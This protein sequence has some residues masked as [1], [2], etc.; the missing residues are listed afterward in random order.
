MVLVHGISGSE[1]SCYMTVAASYLP[2]ARLSGAAASIC[3]A[4]ASPV[5]FAAGSITPAASDDLAAVIAGPRSVAHPP[6]ASCRSA[7]RSAAMCCSSCSA[8]SAAHLPIIKAAS[9]S[10]PIDLAQSSRS[11]MRWRNFGYH[12]FILDSA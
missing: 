11:L 4:P 9:V 5:P 7:S 12:R 8:P 6:R 3:A 10:A 2:G 1:S